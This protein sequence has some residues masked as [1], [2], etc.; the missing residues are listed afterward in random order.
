MSTYAIGDIHG[1]LKAL[2]Q[3]LERIPFTAE[4]TFVFLGDYVDGWSD[5]ANTIEFLIDFAEQHK[6][7][8]IRGNHDYLLSQ[9]L[10][11]HSNNPL[12]LAAGGEVTKANYSDKS[13]AYKAKHV[14]FLDQLVNY[15]I[16]EDNR[17]F[18]HAGFTN[19]HGPQHEYYPNMVY[20]D[21]TLWE[22]A[23]ALDPNMPEDHPRYPKR[24]KL[25]KE[26]YIGHTPVTK[27]G[28]Q[29]VVNCAT[30]WN[31]DT[32][33]AYKGPLS[34]IDVAT[35]AIYTSDPVQEFYPDES[36]RN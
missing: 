15:W 16:D 11:V 26:I 5:A 9:H 25:F 2:K 35:K 12:W 14:E 18:V 19:P 17:L 4:D 21:R 24:L 31:I 27:I 3:L 1:G 7:I 20:W 32:A 36:G 13:A 22:M 34:A 28:E 23:C 33:A 29:S 8:F 30:V 6:C 10:K